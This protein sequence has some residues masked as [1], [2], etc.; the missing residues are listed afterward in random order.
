[1][2]YHPRTYMITAPMIVRGLFDSKS[3]EG[4]L[5]EKAA[6]GKIRLV[7]KPVEW[8]KV[9]WLLVNTFKD[10]AGKPLIFGA[11]LGEIHKALPIEFR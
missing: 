3:P 1:M 4:L 8:N 5:L 7:A 6:C 10:N 11:K 9:L 2:K